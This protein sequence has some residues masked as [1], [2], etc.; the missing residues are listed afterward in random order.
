MMIFVNHRVI[1]A[2]LFNPI[3]ILTKLVRIEYNEVIAAHT[4]CY[5]LSRF[6]IIML[7]ELLDF[8][9]I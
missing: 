4:V 8:D 5:R 9:N 2:K 3:S 6:N 7:S 1:A